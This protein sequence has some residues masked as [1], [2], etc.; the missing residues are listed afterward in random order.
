[1]ERAGGRGGQTCSGACRLHT[2]AYGAKG[3]MVRESL[4]FQRDSS[5]PASRYN[6][7]D[8]GDR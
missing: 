1:V 8:L 2:R 6:L 4:G 3:Q 5:F 7:S